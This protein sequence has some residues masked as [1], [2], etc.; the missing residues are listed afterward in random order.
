MGVIEAALAEHQQCLAFEP[1][2][3]GSLLGV[4]AEG[5][6]GGTVAVGLSGPRRFKAGA[7]RDHVL[8]TAAVSGR[9]EAF[10]AGG[11]VV[12]NVTGYDVPKLLAGSYGTLAVLTEITVK[13]LPR[14]QDQRTVVV[15]GLSA[16]DAVR[17]MTSVLQ[18]A[19][20]VSGA[21]Y[22]PVVPWAEGSVTAF[23][24]EGFAVSVEARLAELTARM[25]ASAT[26]S[27]S[28]LDLETSVEFWRGV[29][30]VRLF[31]SGAREAL[32]WRLSVPPSAAVAV[33]EQ[34]ERSIAGVKL[35]M[36]WGGGLIWVAVDSSES[37]SVI[38][39]ALGDCGGHA[40][41]IRA[42][43]DVRASVDVF[44]PQSSAVSALV[45]RLKAQFDPSRVL[46][47]GRMYADV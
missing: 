10:V 33:V 5:T 30:D 23:R 14:P 13:V 8:G 43:A 25:A 1:P 41:L 42:P 15:S 24:L 35:F 17:V 12:K 16:R 9:G 26:G 6:L 45:K 7:V 29:R 44:Q 4:D 40:T 3:F 21:C 28:T 39:G 37:A 19:I 22:L 2:H 27:V 36:D 20:D 32:V 46:N 11:K 18:S 47:P 34:I 31:D 38:R